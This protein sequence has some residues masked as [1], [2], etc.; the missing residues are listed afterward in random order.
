MAYIVF[1]PLLGDTTKA[2]R[3]LT[4]CQKLN[5]AINLKVGTCTVP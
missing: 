3:I 5:T 2:G 4:V 1:M